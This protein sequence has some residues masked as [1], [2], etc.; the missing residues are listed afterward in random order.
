M[1]NGFADS[2]L[3]YMLCIYVLKYHLLFLVWFNKTIKPEWNLYECISQQLRQY[4][5]GSGLWVQ[6]FSIWPA[7]LEW[8]FQVINRHDRH[9]MTDWDRWINK[10]IENYVTICIH[11]S[12]KAHTSGYYC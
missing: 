9:D 10:L 12:L 7:Q 6:C 11:L 4:L 8:V 5:M 2:F 3:M 1:I